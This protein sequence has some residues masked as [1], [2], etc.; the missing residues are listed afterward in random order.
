MYIVE[1]APK[2]AKVK[3]TIAYDDSNFEGVKS[4]FDHLWVT[5]PMIGNS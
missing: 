1:E 3:V 4:L 2:R 5:K